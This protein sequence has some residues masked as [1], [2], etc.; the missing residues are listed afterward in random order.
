[1]FVRRRSGRVRAR[2]SDGV[3]SPC[4]TARSTSPI[5]ARTSPSVLGSS[6][7][8]GIAGAAGGTMVRMQTTRAVRS[9]LSARSIRARTGT[10]PA[11]TSAARRVVWLRAPVGRPGLPGAKGRPRRFFRTA[12]WAILRESRGC[13]V[14]GGGAVTWLAMGPTWAKFR[15]VSIHN[16]VMACVPGAPWP[17]S[18]TRAGGATYA[19]AESD[20]K[21]C[22]RGP[23]VRETSSCRRAA[24]G[25]WRPARSCRCRAKQ[26]T[27]RDNPGPGSPVPGWPLPR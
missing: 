25:G 1:M 21:T 17:P 4:V 19:P 6:F 16:E 24:A 3:S 12:E 5:A 13:E 15:K 8:V 2:P 9:R 22:R 7:H 27:G 26:V 20:R 18:A 14:G 10:R 23:A 11:F